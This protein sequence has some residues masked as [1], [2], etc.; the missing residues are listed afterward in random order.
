MNVTFKKIPSIA[1]IKNCKIVR[2]QKRWSR[3]ATMHFLTIQYISCIEILPVSRYKCH[4]AIHRYIQ[5]TS[6]IILL[7]YF[8]IIY[9]HS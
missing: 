6:D 7:N 2:W 9:F 1:Y 5:L 4:D 8:E 3:A